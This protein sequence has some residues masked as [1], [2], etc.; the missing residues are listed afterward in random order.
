MMIEIIIQLINFYNILAFPTIF[1][2]DRLA[3]GLGDIEFSTHYAIFEKHAAGVPF[4]L[5]L[6]TGASHEAD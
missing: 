6:I 3:S 5:R 1:S 4:S 2:V